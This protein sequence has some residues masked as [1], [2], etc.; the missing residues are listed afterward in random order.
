MEDRST[1]LILEERTYQVVLTRPLDYRMCV[2]K[3]DQT[4]YHREIDSQWFVLLNP[5]LTQQSRHH[6]ERD[7]S[8]SPT[9]DLRPEYGHFSSL[10]PHTPT[11]DALQEQ[12][13]IGPSPSSH[14]FRGYKIS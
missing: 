14:P 9:M 5:V 1:E 12:S 4:S 2:V 3:D 6:P 10:A 7:I 11:L 8:S 13:L